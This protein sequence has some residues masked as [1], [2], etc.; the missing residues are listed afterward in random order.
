MCLR[1]I[2]VA[3]QISETFFLF[4]SVQRQTTTSQL[5]NPFKLIPTDYK[6]QTNF[7]EQNIFVI[8]GDFQEHNKIF[9]NW[10]FDMSLEKK[11]TIWLVF[12]MSQTFFK[13]T[14]RL[15]SSNASQRHLIN[16][17][18]PTDKVQSAHNVGS[19]WLQNN[20]WKSSNW[21]I[22]ETSQWHP[23]HLSDISKISQFCGT[24]LK[25]FQ[26]HHNF[27]AL[28]SF[29]TFCQKQMSSSHSITQDSCFCFLTMYILVKSQKH[30]INISETY[31]INLCYLWDTSQTKHL[32]IFF[33]SA[34]SRSTW[35]LAWF[36]T[37]S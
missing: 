11:K 14:K 30:L 34:I 22:W 2:L 20:S 16:V 28:K 19:L 17:L 8:F 35:N 7:Q 12:E 3:S 36:L 23:R 29:A 4:S 13:N 15:F 37:N 31:K 25:C 1:D 27:S 24:I 10:E 5:W 18:V 6:W 33:P 9:S 21:C 26:G 32:S